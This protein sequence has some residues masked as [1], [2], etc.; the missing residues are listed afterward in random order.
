[1][2]LLFIG[3]LQE[4]YQQSLTHS[5]AWSVLLSWS[6]VLLQI[7]KK[8][9]FKKYDWFMLNT[10]CFFGMSEN[11]QLLI[12]FFFYFVASLNLG[13]YF[14]MLLAC[15][16]PVKKQPIHSAGSNDTLIT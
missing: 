15:K 4:N 3:G 11:Y 1:M 2:A 8:Y 12:F 5:A 7:G 16:F 13:Y 10:S 14:L 9:A 6:L